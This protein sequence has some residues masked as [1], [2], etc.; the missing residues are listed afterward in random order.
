MARSIKSINKSKT[1]LWIFLLLFFINFSESYG[2]KKA[3]EKIKASIEMGLTLKE[4]LVLVIKNEYKLYL[5]FFSE[6]QRTYEIALSK[7]PIG[8]K[9]NKGD[10]KV[11]EGEY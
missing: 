9:E 7:S 10:L 4:K 6:L 11:P 3:D 2:E 1:I 8:R 5:Y